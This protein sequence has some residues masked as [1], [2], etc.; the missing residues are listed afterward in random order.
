MIFAI[1]APTERPQIE[2]LFDT[3]EKHY[4]V[5]FAPTG[6]MAGSDDWKQ[7]VLQKIDGCRVA[8]IFITEAA[9]A[10][11]TVRWRIATVI[12]KGLMIVP[13]LAD[14]TDFGKLRHLLDG[15]VAKLAFFNAIQYRPEHKERFVDTLL[16]RF[17]GDIPKK[18]IALRCFISYSRKD[19]D[20]AAKISQSLRSKGVD[21]WR[22]EDNIPAGANWDKE[23]ENAIKN[24]SHVVFIATPNSV[25]S[26]NVQDEIS[27]A[28]S[29]KKNIIPVIFGTCELPFRIH[30]AQWI[31]FRG[32]YEGSLAILLKSLGVEKPA[33]AISSRESLVEDVESTATS[34]SSAARQEGEIYT[35]ETPSISTK[36]VKAEKQTV[37]VNILVVSTGSKYTV[38]ISLDSLVGIAVKTLI[39]QIGLPKTFENGLPVIYKLHNKT[40]TRSLDSDQTFRQNEVQD[41]DT[42]SFHIDMVAG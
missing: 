2:F 14:N 26:E 40:Q 4:E 6:L 8:I 25:A 36:I 39:E 13:I 21:V 16:N 11:E 10:D 7:K 41:G 23:I 33:S 15:E 35:A 29:Q 30:R 17:L 12:E 27:L 22:D 42:L 32:D 24:C 1:Y 19:R 18:T 38:E 20:T 9:L 28:L 5:S 37:T 31:D 3:L 34:A